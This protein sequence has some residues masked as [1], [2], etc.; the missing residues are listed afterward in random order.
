VPDETRRG[1]EVKPERNL[2]ARKYSM[3]LEEILG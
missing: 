2:W 1:S 3:E